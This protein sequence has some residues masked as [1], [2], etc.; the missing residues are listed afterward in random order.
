[1]SGGA[2]PRLAVFDLDG[3]LTRSDTLVSFIAAAL[4]HWPARMLRLPAV[5]L[6]LLGYALRIIDRGALKGAVMHLLLAGLDRRRL[7]DIAG[8]F[9]Y[10]VLDTSLHAEAREVIAAHKAAGDRLVLMSAS[11]DLYVPRIGALL[12]FDE[13]L[14]TAVRW[15][16]EAFDGRLA[17]PNCRGPEKSQRLQVLRSRHPG[18][19]A[20][21][22]GNTESD[23]DHMR[24]CESAV[25]VNAGRRLAQRL[26]ATGIDLVQWH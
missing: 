16:G 11:P 15:E 5:L 22:Y 7:E 19:A 2:A 18:L 20:I 26:A 6:P 25:F 9:A 17:G 12:G 21:A 13:T 8:S 1:M 14:C 24:L 10:E 4:M 23:L 3:T